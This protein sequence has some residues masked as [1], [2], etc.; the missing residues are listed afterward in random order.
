M[1]AIPVRVQ[2]GSLIYVPP[3]LQVIST[4]VLLEQEAWFEDEF[5]FVS[6]CVQPGELAVDVGANFGV[7]ATA[8]GRAVGSEGRVLA[9]EPTAQTAT[10]L[11]A[12]AGSNLD[13]PIEVVQAAVSDREGAAFLQSGASPE[14]NAVSEGSGARNGEKISLMTLD[15]VLEKSN[16]PFTFAKIDAEGHEPQVIAGAR[17][18]LR[19]HEPMLMLEITHGAGTDLSRL[20]AL[21]ESGYRYFHLLPGLNLLVPFARDAGVDQFQ[22]NLFAC[23][24]R[25]AEILRA[26]GRLVVES[27]LLAVAPPEAW[28]TCPEIVPT[29]AA[30]GTRST[31]YRES[32]G[33]YA[34][35]RSASDSAT[36]AGHLREAFKTAAAACQER[37]SVSRQLTLARI[38]RDAGARFLAMEIYSRIV[39]HLLANQPLSVDEACLRP[40]TWAVSAEKNS[41]PGAFRTRL[42]EAYERTRHFSSYYVGPSGL[43]F[44]DV[45]C[46]D[47]NA[48][49][50]MHRRRQLLRMRAGLQSRPEPHPSLAAP[51]PDNLN[52]E[53]W[54]GTGAAAAPKN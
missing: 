40:A 26:R 5:H 17:K 41:D 3:S 36:K 2:G 32:L 48:S 54:T 18:I 15:R 33:H 34:T 47:P 53:F 38:A 21:A 4:Y 29:T 14:L 22:L 9:F 37:N 43:P 30:A 1:Q 11:R 13:A 19:D 39:G 35:A 50:Q 31:L 45:V 46:A 27:D 42:F 49:P 10:F 28:E 25:R 8:L 6:H 20:T 16:R 44:L 24:S 12:T 7:Y 51:R 23:T 52:P